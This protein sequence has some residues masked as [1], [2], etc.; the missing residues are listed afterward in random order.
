MSNSLN[1]VVLQNFEFVVKAVTVEIENGF[2]ITNDKNVIGKKLSKFNNIEKIIGDMEYSFFFSGKPVVI[3]EINL[4]DANDP[5]LELKVF[6]YTLQ[7]LFVSFWA[8]KDSCVDTEMGFLLTPTDVHSN[9]IKL[10]FINS[11]C[12]KNILKV[13]FKECNTIV[14]EYYNNFD[15]NVKNQIGSP[16]IL[17]KETSKLWRAIYHFGR[18][19]SSSTFELKISDYCSGF[20]ALLSTSPNE[21]A[22]QLADLALL[23]E[24]TIEKRIEI[25][26]SIKK[27][28]GV[29]SKVVH[30]SP[31]DDK[32]LCDYCKLSDTIARTVFNKIHKDRE[33]FELFDTNKPDRIDEYFL[34][35][36]FQ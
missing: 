22:H 36:L 13:D 35:L 4:K 24:S 8:Y 6:L 3:K 2:I 10:G 17:N 18:A 12:K 20:E 19:R 1:I 15:R 7:S 11:D 9:M 30:G 34:N 21:I 16:T 5:M 28:Y 32:E 29:R 23:T 31:I 25:Y 33:L 27:I 26:R 14:R